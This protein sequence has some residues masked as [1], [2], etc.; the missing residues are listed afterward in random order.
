MKNWTRPK[1][2]VQKFVPNFCVL[3]CYTDFYEG[4]AWVDNSQA[5]KKD[6]WDDDDK[7]NPNFPR[8]T[9]DGKTYI[10][11]SSSDFVTSW[12]PYSAWKR[13]GLNDDVPVVGYYETSSGEDPEFVNY[14]GIVMIEQGAHN[15]FQQYYYIE[16]TS[17]P[18]LARTMT[19]AS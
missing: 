4:E 13:N 19:N 9:A 6:F 3:N 15:P 10:K 17:T 7:Y 5:G 14:K 2:K 8:T 16:T 1:I 11:R 12:N 18:I